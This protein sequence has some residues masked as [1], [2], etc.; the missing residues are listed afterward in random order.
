MSRSKWKGPFINTKISSLKKNTLEILGRNSKILPK[1]IGQNI[2]IHNGKEHFEL[3]LTKEMLG[4]EL[5]E[6]VFTRAKFSF[7]KKAK[8]LSLNKKTRS[9]K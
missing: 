1:F 5:G 9:K 7:K 8:K 3:A 6:F 4:H 2:K